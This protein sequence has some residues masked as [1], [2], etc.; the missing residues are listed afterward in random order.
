MN[1]HAEHKSKSKQ[2]GQH[3]ERHLGSVAV[4]CHLRI[5]V[6]DGVEGALILQTE[7]EDDSINPSRELRGQEPVREMRLDM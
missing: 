6:I 3:D 7:H 2:T 4:V 5:V 1:Q